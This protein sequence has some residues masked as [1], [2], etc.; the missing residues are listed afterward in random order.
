MGFIWC[1]E[2]ERMNEFYIWVSIY[3]NIIVSVD[4]NKFLVL[5]GQL[6]FTRHNENSWIDGGYTKII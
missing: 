5:T 6:G 3:S 1:R 4:D 2:I